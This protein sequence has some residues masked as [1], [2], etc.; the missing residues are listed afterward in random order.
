MGF[1][2]TARIGAARPAISELDVSRRHRPD[3]TSPHLKFGYAKVMETRAIRARLIAEGVTDDWR[4]HLAVERE[5]EAAHA[6]DPTYAE[7]SARLRAEAAARAFVAVETFTPEELLRIAEH[8]AG[9]NDP[10]A[11]A[12]ARKARR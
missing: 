8:F 7:T 6:N 2:L 12:I 10:V 4:L 5:Y 9:A 11:Q 1:S 3:P